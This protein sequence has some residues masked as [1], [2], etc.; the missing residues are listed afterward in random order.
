MAP[1]HTRTELRV[2]AALQRSPRG[3]LSARAVARKAGVSPTA[4]SRALTRLRARG[5]TRRVP[6][7]VAEG[8][9]RRASVWRLDHRS[10]RWPALAPVLAAVERPATATTPASGLPRRLDHLFWNLEPRRLDLKH[11]AVLVAQRIL[12]SDDLDALAWAARHLPGT[13]W[14][15]VAEQRRLDPRRRALA[16][17]LASDAA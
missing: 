2:L 13:A 5:L 4:A 3:A 16:A 9:A 6:V 12:R 14:R 11:D 15:A 7:T 8:A 10:P 1:T 17:N